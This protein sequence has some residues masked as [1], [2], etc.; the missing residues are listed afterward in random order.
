MVHWFVVNR[1]PDDY[2]TAFAAEG[3]VGR[4]IEPLIGV[5]G[6]FL[7]IVLLW[8]GRMIISHLYRCSVY[9]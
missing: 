2:A 9:S 8:A 6:I 5:G 7:L 4:S 1:D 3:L